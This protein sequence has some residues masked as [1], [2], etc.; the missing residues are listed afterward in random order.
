MFLFEFELVRGRTDILNSLILCPVKFLFLLLVGGG[1]HAAL[2]SLLG[3]LYLS[4]VIV[5]MVKLVE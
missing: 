1:V 4:R 3:L 2:R 5:R